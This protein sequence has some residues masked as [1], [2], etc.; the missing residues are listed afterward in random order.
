MRE[1]AV[2]RPTL[3]FSFRSAPDVPDI[4]RRT[5][6]RNW[7]SKRRHYVLKCI[8]RQKC[9][10]YLTLWKRNLKSRY[11]SKLFG[12]GPHWGIYVE[13]QYVFV[14]KSVMKVET[15]SHGFTFQ[16]DDPLLDVSVRSGRCQQRTNLLTNFCRTSCVHTTTSKLRRYTV[17]LSVQTFQVKSYPAN[18]Y[19]EQFV[20]YTNLCLIEN[21]VSCMHCSKKPI[22]TLTLWLGSVVVE[23]RTSDRKIASSTPGRCIA[24]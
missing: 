12:E 17:S 8:R 9:T 1:D 15:G 3:F 5:D 24:G 19:S 18:S 11:R 21:C 16:V 22:F 4:D 2:D 13:R 20:L 10:A 7:S 6:R 14:E 23:R